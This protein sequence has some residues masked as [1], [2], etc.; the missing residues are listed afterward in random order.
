MT[1]RPL[2]DPWWLPGL[3]IEPEA[4]HHGQTP[5]GARF[6]T[7]HLDGKAADRVARAVRGAAL[8]ARNRRSLSEVAEAIGGAA[9]EL[10]DPDTRVGATAV[11]LLGAEMGWS[12]ELAVE[13]LEGMAAAWTPGTLL[14]LVRSELGSTALLEG[15]GP[16]EELAD[17]SRRRRRAL[18]PR[19]LFVV[20]AGNLPGVAVTS[21]LRGLLVRSGVLSKTARGEP[22]LVPLFAAAL[23]GRDQLLAASMASTWW[24]GGGDDPAFAAW[25]QRAGSVVAYGGREAVEGIR[26]RVPARTDLVVYGPKIGLAALLPDALETEERRAQ[27]ARRLAEDVCAY[28]QMGCVSPRL[29]FVLGQGPDAF[30]RDLADALRRQVERRPPPEPD[31]ATAV[32]LRSLRARAEFRGYA[33]E[34][35][36]RVLSSR[37]GLAWTVIVG[38]DDPLRTEGLPRV[39][40]VHGVESLQ[41]LRRLLTPLEGAVQTVGYAGREGVEQLADLAV[42]LGTAR[43]SPLGSVAWPPADWRHDGRSQLLPLLRWTDWEMPG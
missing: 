17:G 35:G 37:E 38:G 19:L 12:R 2:E 9:L 5:R 30:A 27:A 31:P 11:E 40:G 4:R 14:D 18:G 8:E 36:P 1:D 23:H 13:T 42:D 33:G 34:G 6:T 28:E 16:D 7:P 41:R 21:V 29:V 26:G 3:E 43:L 39:V 22:G 32:A 20:Q 25:A 24:P 10:A 15:W